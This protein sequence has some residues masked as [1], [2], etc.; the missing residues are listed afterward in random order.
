[1]SLRT[2]PR[3]RYLALK[4]ESNKTFDKRTL[5][6]KIW[7]S[8]TRLYGEYGASKANLVLIDYKPEEGFAILRCNNNGI[9]MVRA[10]IAIITQ[11]MEAQVAIHVLAISGTIKALRRKLSQTQNV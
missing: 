4:I 7:N 8:L 10:A 2:K 6:N 1:M 3:H 5:L 11:I 9:L